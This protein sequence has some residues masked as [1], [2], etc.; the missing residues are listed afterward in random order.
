MALDT[1]MPAEL[2]AAVATDYLANSSVK[3]APLLGML[4]A[5]AIYQPQKEIT[6]G[7]KV[8]NAVVGGRAVGG[9]LG[10]DNNG[11]DKAATLSVP[12]YLV[13]HQFTVLKRDLVNAA[14]TGRITATR[15]PV[16]NNVTDAVNE[17][18]RKLNQVLYSGNGTV[19]ATHFG[20][21]GLNT[22]AV[23]TGNYAG[24]SR[25]TYPKWRSI[26]NQGAVP[27][28]L[29]NL[30]VD[31]ISAVLRARRAAGVADRYTMGNDLVILCGD[32][33]E[34][35]VLRKLYAN[36]TNEQTLYEMASKDIQPYI[37]YFVRGIPVVSDIDCPA[38]T[39]YV[40]NLAK[41]GIY[42]FDDRETNVGNPKVDYIPLRV[43]G[44]EDST[45]YIR[46]ADVSDNH[47]DVYTLELSVSLQLAIWD[48]KDGLTKVED[49]RHDIT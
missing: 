33:I 27:G 29:E 40:A 49:V 39:M 10:N 24:L 22:A 3:E 15:N 19:D 37:N 31:R 32:E 12:D 41:M 7:A 14:T 46:L 2:L 1:L 23:Q 16:S 28:T 5:N 6:W 9:A 48:L 43:D 42:G 45:I 47:P 20:V 25:T 34:K 36:A 13:K 17:I 26:L 21:V 35:D 30:T 38:N 8:G 11:T 18:T 44:F 4:S